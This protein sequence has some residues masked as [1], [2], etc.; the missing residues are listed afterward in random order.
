[1]DNNT[2]FGFVILHYCSINETINCIESIQSK[3]DYDNYYIVIVDNGSPNNTGKELEH[4]YGNNRHCVVLLNKDNLG[5]ARGN[6]VGFRYAKFILNCNYICMLNSDTKLISDNFCELAINYFEEYKYSVAGPDVIN[7]DC[8]QSNPMEGHILTVEETDQKVR[9][10]KFQ[11]LLNRINADKTARRII[12]IIKGNME[13]KSS[14]I[15]DKAFVNVKLHGCCW[16]F[17][18]LYIEKYDGI[19]EITFLYLE[20]DLL[21]HIV[22]KDGGSTLYAPEIKIY[23]EGGASTDITKCDRLKRKYVLEN[24]L[25]SM[26]AINRYLKTEKETK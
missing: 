4:Q 24:H 7:K 14:Y 23:H 16:I 9:S 10:L 15:R 26:T 22:V 18:P 25:K 6:N 13:G 20:E 17:S 1:M 11:L 3:I 21:Y 5:F 12:R 8:S 2:V 19:S